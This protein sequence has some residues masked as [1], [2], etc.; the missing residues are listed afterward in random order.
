ME[1]RNIV[2]GLD[3]VSWNFLSSWMEEGNLPNIQSFKEDGCYSDMD[4]VIP[5]VTCPAWRCYSTGKNPGKLGVFWWLNFDRSK[6]RTVLPNSA[7]FKS[8]DFWHYI[9]NGGKKVCIINMPM[10]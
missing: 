4:S 9:G 5:P 2:L 8:K 10:T 6:G 7:S 3:G 1:K